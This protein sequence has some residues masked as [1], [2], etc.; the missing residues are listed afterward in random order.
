MI[1]Q[2]IFFFF[3]NKYHGTWPVEFVECVFGWSSMRCWACLWGFRCAALLWFCICWFWLSLMVCFTVILLNTL[4]LMRSQR[5]L[6]M[7]RLWSNGVCV[8]GVELSVPAVPGR[9]PQTVFV[10]SEFLAPHKLT[11]TRQIN[12]TINQHW[13]FSPIYSQA[14]L[15]ALYLHIHNWVVVI[16]IKNLF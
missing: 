16:F 11:N 6:V 2:L 10:L 9:V 3:F 13:A 5:T 14:L 1:L 12:T 7:P 8:L 4:R 15:Q